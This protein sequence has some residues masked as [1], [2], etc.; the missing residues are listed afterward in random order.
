MKINYKYSILLTFVSLFLFWITIKYGSFV[1]QHFC[2]V[3]EG[4]TDFEKYSHKVIPYPE[5]AL[6][7]YNDIHSPLYSQTVNLPINDPVSCKNFCGPKATCSITGEQCTSDVDCFGCK[8]VSKNENNCTSKDVTPYDATGKLGQQLQYSSLTTGYNGNNI[9]FAEVYQGSKEKQLTPPYQGYDI[10]TDTFNKGLEIYNKKRESADK[11]SSAS[12]GFGFGS[13]KQYYE[14]QYPMSVSLTGQF[15]QT[16]PPASNSSQT[17][18]Q[19]SDA[20][21]N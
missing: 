1:L 13:K 18:L 5:N 7:N 10:W 6:I 15:Y 14:P 9:G 21:L 11:Y 16:T 4:L 2:S 3:K 12:M 20:S 8:P 17:L 19:S